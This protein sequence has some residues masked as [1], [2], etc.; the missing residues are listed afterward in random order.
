MDG[1]LRRNGQASAGMALYCY[2]EDNEK[3][4]FCR[5][6]RLLTTITSSLAAE[7]MGFQ[8]GLEIFATRVS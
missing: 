1:A 5:A 4:L 7:L 2:D 6:G 8:L 3:K